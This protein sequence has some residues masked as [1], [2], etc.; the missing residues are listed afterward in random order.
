MTSD[1]APIEERAPVRGWAR[2]A[3]YGGGGPAGTAWRAV[4][5]P[6]ARVWEASAER[7]LAARRDAV[8]LPAPAIAIGNV[9]VGGGG[10]T[11]LV[12]WLLAEGI[13]T[14]TRGAVLT[15]GYGR[16]S[17][18]VWVL[19]PG[20]TTRELARQAGDEP[21]LLARRGAWIG[22]GA[23]RARAARAVVA[24]V[25][26]DV[27]LLDDALQHRRVAR[28]LDLVAFT[29]ADLEAP[30]RC[31]PGGPLRQGPGWQPALGA[32]VVVGPDP[33]SRTWPPRT[34]GRAFQAWWSELPGTSASWKI[35][36]TQTLESWLDGTGTRF[37]PGAREVVAF[38]GVARP[39]SVGPS[40]ESAGLRVAALAAFPDHWSY[41]AG[42]IHALF[43]EY[44]DAAFVTTEKDAVKLDPR[45]FED[46]PVGVLRR[47][48]VPHAP[49]LLRELAREA[50]GA[51]ADGP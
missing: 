34:I 14:G 12:E 40:A 36:E 20:P 2:R 41:R 47:R 35:E 33:R 18:D 25:Q 30:A 13:P 46:R 49:E 32:W 24:R 51:A 23:D 37:E 19:A 15:S 1:Q 8:R 21:A 28:A 9:T 38:A 26:P 4:A 48:L 10:K 43:R 16:R 22:V 7:R 45:W 6:L 39:D 29:T 17:D 42:H 5:R 50:M 11:S 44:P 3:L 31:L 27:F